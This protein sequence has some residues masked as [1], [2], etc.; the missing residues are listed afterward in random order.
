MNKYRDWIYPI[1]IGMFMALSIYVLVMTME[2]PEKRMERA[3]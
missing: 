1:I 2:M 3:K